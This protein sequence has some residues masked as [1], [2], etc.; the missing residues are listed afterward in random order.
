MGT[1][2]LM[3]TDFQFCMMKTVLEGLPGSPVVKNPPA[4]ARDMS[5]VP[6]PGQSHMHQSN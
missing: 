2:S 6:G 1:W 4:N 5:L 3:G